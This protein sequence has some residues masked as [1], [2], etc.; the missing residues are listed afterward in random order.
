MQK[1]NV[2]V[3]IDTPY[4]TI[5]EYAKRIGLSSRAVAERARAGEYPLKPRKSSADKI[6]INNALLIKQALEAKF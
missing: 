5:E 1:S 6:F 2:I 4:L 3:S